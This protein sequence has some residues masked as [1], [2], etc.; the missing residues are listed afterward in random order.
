MITLVERSVRTCM[1]PRIYGA[2]WMGL[3][4]HISVEKDT[5]ESIVEDTEEDNVAVDTV[6]ETF[7]G[8]TSGGRHGGRCRR[9][10]SVVIR[11]HEDILTYLTGKHSLKPV[12][13]SH[14]LPTRLIKPEEMAQGRHSINEVRYGSIISS[15]LPSLKV[16]SNSSSLRNYYSA[17]R[18]G[19]HKPRHHQPA[20]FFKTRTTESTLPGDQLPTLCMCAA[21]IFNGA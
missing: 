21:L 3:N 20:S 10:F 13:P 1:L 2:R 7:E 8:F 16:R 11:I 4:Q 17:R 15:F 19:L 14:A 12:P 5:E 18:R 9:N 6:E